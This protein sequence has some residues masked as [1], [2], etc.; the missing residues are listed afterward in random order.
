MRKV[1]ISRMSYS[2]L[3]SR[4][5]E[6]G[7]VS[8]FVVV[9]C[10][11]LMTVLT[12]S[13]IRIMVQEQQQ[14]AANDLS[15]SAYD[16]A[17]AGVEDAKRALLLC[18]RGND[19]VCGTLDRAVDACES[20]PDA[21]SGHTG[22]M[23]TSPDTGNKEMKIQTSAGDEK[24]DQ[25]YTCVKVDRTP[26]EYPGSLDAGASKIIPLKTGGESFDRIRL[27]W[28][29]YEDLKKVGI[30]SRAIALDT[31]PDWSVAQLLP[32]S[33]N[34]WP[35]NRPSLMRA[36]LMQFDAGGFTLDS[37]NNAAGDGKSNANT[38]FLY[39]TRSAA[40]G[41]VNFTD[42]KRQGQD[43]VSGGGRLNTVRCKEDFDA[44]PPSVYAC[45]IDMVLPE[46]VNSTSGGRTAYLRLSGL[47]NATSYS[48]TLLRGTET[49][50]F[51]GV[52]AKI[53]ATGR[54]NDLFR[55]VESTV[56]LEPINFPYPEAAVDIS[57]DLCKNFVV[58]DGT[59]PNSGY[60]AGSCTP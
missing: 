13:F 37:F 7:A 31:T 14:A 51:D 33:N 11:L 22:S 39:P 5:N 47:Y 58:T 18:Q 6:Q 41:S 28:F 49:I 23:S 25:A 43:A 17:Q 16:S 21:L 15:Q 19:D 32:A 12:I 4:K 45:S 8:L 3:Q 10:A 40:S 56:E 44:A 36:Q 46:P 38:I 52:I 55:R 50:P 34:T 1:G 9:F 27:S 35:K 2:A 42:D 24:L 54:A 57:G 20:V 59:G 53:D 60:S 48:V 29:A 30:T 26:D